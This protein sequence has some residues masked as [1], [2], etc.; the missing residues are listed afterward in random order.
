LKGEPK[1]QNKNSEKLLTDLSQ[2]NKAK[3]RIQDIPWF[4]VERKYSCFTKKNS[5]GETKLRQIN[6][7]A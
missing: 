2:G 3:G 5:T 4:G 6:F 7:K 1:I